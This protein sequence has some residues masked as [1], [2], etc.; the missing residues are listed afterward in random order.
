MLPFPNCHPLVFCD[1]LL[2]FL[3]LAFCSCSYWL[4]VVRQIT[5]VPAAI[6]QVFRPTLHTAATH[7]GL[8]TDMTKLIR[9]VLLHKKFHYGTLMVYYITVSQSVAVDYGQV[10]VGLCCTC[11]SSCKKG[12]QLLAQSCSINKI[13][14]NLCCSLRSL[15]PSY[16]Y[17]LHE[18]LN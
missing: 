13:Y 15:E 3:L 7:A 5:D 10:F 6:L 12:I 11:V 17:L 14:I 1:E 2:N 9:I 8:S 16:I 18:I 4:T